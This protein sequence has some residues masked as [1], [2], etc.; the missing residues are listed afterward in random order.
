MLFYV[1]QDL[2]DFLKRVEPMI[3]AALKSNTQSHAFDGNYSTSLLITCSV[4]IIIMYMY[5]CMY[6][7][8]RLS[9][10]KLIFRN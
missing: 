6:F 3:T 7:V 8:D 9:I 2:R 5:T 10:D 1:L 4:T